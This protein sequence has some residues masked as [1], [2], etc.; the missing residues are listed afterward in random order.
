MNNIL[1]P[2]FSAGDY[3]VPYG[4]QNI[5]RELLEVKI[6]KRGGRVVTT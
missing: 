3:I 6:I 1:N 2:C 4:P 5:P